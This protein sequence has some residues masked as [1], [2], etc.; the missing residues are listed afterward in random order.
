MTN[1]SVSLVQAELIWEQPQ[2]NLGHL[3]GLIEAVTSD[4]I[5]LPEMFSTGFSM[6]SGRLAEE[7]SGPTVKWL[8]DKARA[9]H[10]HICGS[11]I[12]TDEGRYWNRF[13]WMKPD[14]EAITYD[15]RHLFRMSAEHEHY[16]PGE[17]TVT[18]EVNGIRVRP[19]ICYDLRFPVWSRNRDDYDLLIY[20]AN[21]PAARRK[22]WQALLQARAI[23]NQSYCVGVN[24]IGVDGNDVAYCGDSIAVDYRGDIMT[25]LGSAEGVMNVSFDRLELDGYRQAFPAGMD[26]DRFTIEDS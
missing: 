18:I 9:K 15:K 3:G 24:R 7:M 4:V 8:A 11:L 10:S 17:H 5:V 25:D 21:W 6:A 26:A 19:L 2:V 13:I 23:E 20:V 16:S 12:I 22:H 14:G 1:L